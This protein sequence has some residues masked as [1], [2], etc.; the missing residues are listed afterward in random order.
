[1]T[2]IGS[3]QLMSAGMDNMTNGA[4]T[5]YNLKVY[6]KTP[7]YDRDVLEIRLPYELELP[8]YV[9]QLTCKA[10]KNINRISCV[11]SSNNF[12]R[13]TFES[14]DAINPGDLI[15]IWL[16]TIRNAPSLRPTSPFTDIL[17]KDGAGYKVSG[18]SGIVSVTNY[19][20]SF[21]LD[22]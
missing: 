8:R 11:A 19:N 13:I 17:L 12:I 18:Y 21:I 4:W 16:N 9:S 14:V 22:Y 15:T 10:S 2:D 7:I 1:M 20:A 6:P 5:Q 3:L